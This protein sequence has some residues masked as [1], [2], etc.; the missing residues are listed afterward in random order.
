MHEGMNTGVLWARPKKGLH[1]LCSHFI[2][3]KVAIRPLVKCIA[4]VVQENRGFGDQQ[5]V[6]ATGEIW[7]LLCFWLEQ[8]MMDGI[9][10]CIGDYKR[11]IWSGEEREMKSSHWNIFSLMCSWDIQVG[12]CNWKMVVQAWFSLRDIRFRDI[13]LES[14]PIIKCLIF[15]VISA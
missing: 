2:G 11:R 5:A 15:G 9:S 14:H 4:H 3:E 1:H 7:W 10:K 12:I 13:Q 6:S 8:L